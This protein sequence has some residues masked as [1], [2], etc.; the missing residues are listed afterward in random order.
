MGDGLGV[1]KNDCPKG[2]VMGVSN[3]DIL[4]FVGVVGTET[5]SASETS[6]SRSSQTGKRTLE[7]VLSFLAGTFEGIGADLA[8]SNLDNG[9]LAAIGMLTGLEGGGVGRPWGCLEMAILPEGLDKCRGLVS[10]NGS[11]SLEEGSSACEGSSMGG[12]GC[13]EPRRPPLTVECDDALLVAG[14]SFFA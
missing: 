6:S 3:A 8:P 5:A 11:N 2:A 7:P 1:G 9:F 4:D 13:L 10:A 14:R 12:D